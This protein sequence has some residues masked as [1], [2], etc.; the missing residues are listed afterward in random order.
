[1]EKDTEEDKYDVSKLSLETLKNPK[2]LIAGAIAALGG[3]MY[4]GDGFTFEFSTCVVEEDE[5]ALEVIELEAPEEPQ[6]DPEEA[7]EEPEAAS[8]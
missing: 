5:T 7:P 2:M 8:G 4:A 1:M 3:V 6:E